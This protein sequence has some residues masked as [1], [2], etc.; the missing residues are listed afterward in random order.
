[1]LALLA[2]VLDETESGL[3]MV[4]HD[5]ADAARIADQVIFVDEGIATSPAE[6]G[7]LLADPPPALKAYLG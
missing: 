5:P 4:T 2:D 6:T 3:I 7:Q 1:M